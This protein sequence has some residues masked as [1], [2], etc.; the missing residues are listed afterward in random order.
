MEEKREQAGVMRKTGMSYSEIKE[1]LGIP[2]STLSTWFKKEEWS[3]AISSE[4]AKRHARLG[5]MRLMVMNTVRGNRLKKLYEDARQ[6]ALADFTDL[7][8][9]PLFLSGI[10]LYWAHGDKSS[11]GRFSVSS[12]DIGVIRVV[13]LFLE[14]ICCIEKY[15]ISL[16]VDPKMPD[17]ICRKYWMSKCGFKYSDF[18][19]SIFVRHKKYHGKIHYGICNIAVSSAYLKSKIMKW[20][21]LVEED[22]VSET[23]LK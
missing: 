5:A 3:N 23:Y 13:K 12:G 9:H 21:E 10:I 2:R 19:K 7:K 8:Y 22:L 1:K 6:D 15:R 18:G 16:I 17:S 11:K 4:V 14:N 20:I